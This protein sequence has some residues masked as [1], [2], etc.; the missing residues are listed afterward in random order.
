MQFRETRKSRG[1]R[2]MKT[3]KVINQKR[4]RMKIIKMRMR[5]IQTKMCSTR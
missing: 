2:R 3:I 4:M 1:I 5:W